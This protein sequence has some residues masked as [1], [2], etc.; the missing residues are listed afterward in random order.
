MPRLV[1]ENSW[2]GSA[3]FTFLFIFP[4]SFPAVSW[5]ASRNWMVAKCCKD[6]AACNTTESNQP[7]SECSELVHAV[8]NASQ[9]SKHVANHPVNMQNR[10]R[11]RM[12]QNYLMFTCSVTLRSLVFS[13]SFDRS[14]HIAT[15]DNIRIIIIP[16]RFPCASKVPTLFLYLQSD[17]NINEW[18]A[19]STYVH[20]IDRQQNS[21]RLRFGLSLPKVSIWSK[22]WLAN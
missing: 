3:F 18:C 19:T 1:V 22:T 16:I 7:K 21:P 15:Y 9:Y 14:W 11:N 12:V 8:S 6:L 5:W 13:F 2:N 4:F 20:Q 10:K 17:M